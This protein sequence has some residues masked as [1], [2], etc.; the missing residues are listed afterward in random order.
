MAPLRTYQKITTAPLV[1]ISNFRRNMI[2]FFW[3]AC[4]GMGSNITEER[5]ETNHL[6]VSPSVDFD[7]EYTVN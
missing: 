3:G 1:N 6:S 7:L 4:I 2:E 5:R